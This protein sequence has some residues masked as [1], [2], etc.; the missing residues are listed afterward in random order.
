MS[1]TPNRIKLQGKIVEM[2]GDEMTRVLWKLIKEKIIFPVFEIEN[3]LEYYDLSIQNRDKTEDKITAEAAHATVKHGVAIKCATITADA[4]R[5]KEFKLA[6]MWRSPNATIR[7]IIGGTIF[8]EPIVVT[9]VPRLVP[10][11]QH[12]IAIG[13]HGYG[14]QYACK[15][16]VVP[17]GVSGTVEMR[18]VPDNEADK[19]KHMK[20]FKVHHFAANSGGGVM[21][22]MYNRNDSIDNF[23]RACFHFALEKKWPLYLS[24]KNTVLRQYDG[25]FKDRFQSIFEKE[26]FKEKFAQAGITYEHR[27]IDDMVAQCLRSSGRFVWACKNY[28]GDVQS[29][30]VAQGFGSLGLMTSVL[31]SADGKVFESEAAHGTVT[32]HWR[33]HQNGEETSTNPVA[34]IFAW[35]RGIQRRAQLDLQQ[36]ENNSTEHQMLQLAIDA[37]A[38][39]EKSVIGVIEG[40]KMTKDLAICIRGNNEDAVKRNEWLNTFE[41][42]DACSEAVKKGFEELMIKNKKKQNLSKL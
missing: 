6:K 37:C 21:M 27:L 10:H 20:T 16:A 34:S 14:D 4:A 19:A 25:T 5:V 30:S 24:T 39:I 3:N 35:T 7:T 36:A 33:Q 38:M 32:K 12:P 18:F 1:T 11:W 23:A 26:G 22:T 40:G 42:L 17:A 28:D 15:D 31:I 8:R 29:D 41:F 13:R 2:D 9:N